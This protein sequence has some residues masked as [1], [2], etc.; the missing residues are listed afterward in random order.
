MKKIIITLLIC[1]TFNSVSAKSFVDEVSDIVGVSPD[2]NI[3]LGTGII[4][5]LIAF[6]DDDDAKEVGKIMENL[7]KIRISV[8]ELDNNVNTDKLNT[9]IQSKV[10]KLL[11]QGYES[12]VTVRDKSE[13]VNILAKVQGE[14]LED[15]MLIVMD[16]GDEMVVITLQGLID[17]AQIAELTEHF[18]V[19]INDIAFN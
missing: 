1:L 14:N 6:S 4:N 2:V 19:D 8:F 11:K 16:E 3:N 12:I 13:T 9:L 15:A 18:D 17:L 7:D 5:A 10:N